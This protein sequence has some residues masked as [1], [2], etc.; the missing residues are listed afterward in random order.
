MVAAIE[1]LGFSEECLN[2]VFRRNADAL[3]EAA[4]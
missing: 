2:L 3:L 1:S 4:R